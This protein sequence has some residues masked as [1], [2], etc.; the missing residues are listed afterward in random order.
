MKKNMMLLILFSLFLSACSLNQSKIEYPK[1]PKE[2]V[3]D[4][5]FGT[6]VNDSYRWM[7]NDTSQAIKDWVETEN[8]ITFDYLSKIPFRDK[9]KERYSKLFNYPKFSAPFRGGKNYF[10][11]KNDGLQNQSV[12]YIQKGLDGKP[13]LFLDPNK[14]KSDGTVALS[15]YSISKNGKYFA[16][17]T[18]SGGSDWNEFYVMN[19]SA[20][21]KLND[22]LNWIK[23]SGISWYKDGFFYSRFPKPSKGKELTTANE[24]H[25]VYY[26]KIGTDQKNDKMIIGDRNNPK[27]TFYAQTTEDERYLIIYS[28]KGTSNNALSVKDLSANSKFK[29]MVA[30]FE[31]NYNVIDNVGNKLL[32]LTDKNAPK[33]Q[34]VLIDP[35]NPNEKN[36]KVIIPENENVLRSVDIIGG[37]IIANYMKDASTHIYMHSMEGKLENEIKLP[38]IG[39]VGGFSGKKN[40]DIAFYTFTSF[41]YPSSIYKFEVNK[42]K[43]SL[44]QQPNIDFDFSPYETEQVFYKSKDGT[45]IP[46][47][48]VHKKGI[49]MDGSNPTYLYA[50]GGFNI[51]LT[52]S[53][54]SSRLIW[55]EQDGIFAMPNLRGGGEYGEAWHEA[56]TKLKKQNV[57]DDFISAA[58]YLINNKYTSPEKL[59]CAGGSNGGLLIGA[60]INQKPDL[61][62]V[63]LPAVGVMD[64][65]R[66]HKFTIGWAWVSDYGSSDDSLEF[67]ALYKYSPL[68]N[69]KSDLDYPAVLVTTADHDD[70]VVPG[71]SFKYTAT[72]QEK[73]KGNNP[74]LIRIGVRAGHGSGKPTT[75]IIEE[76]ADIYSFVFYNLGME[77]KY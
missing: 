65:L 59:V 58:E 37:K 56:G 38:A 25:S 46:M 39:T 74:I 57:F 44:Y 32:V 18:A 69:I 42:N 7:E 68:H 73:Y 21:E 55:L 1:P 76:Q 72:L 61:F 13:D 27:M 36:W 62:K 48:I 33:N 19:V 6:V 4:N 12:L 8:K 50:Y 70:R 35:N 67:G 10:F 26:H 49:K 22:H 24:Y 77:P 28:S 31:N 17:G 29:T 2:D 16:Y 3:K 54:S 45:S 47:F 53:F 5:Y 75:K 15:N 40:D 43:S 51:S 71:H 23:F 64:M 30:D 34:L 11:F 66:F 9:I 14:L 60:T 63:A 52:P 20:K 41:T